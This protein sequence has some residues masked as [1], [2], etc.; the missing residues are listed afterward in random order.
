MSRLISKPK[1][2]PDKQ[3]KLDSLRK[4]D[5]TKLLWECPTCGITYTPS[6][7]KPLLSRCPYCFPEDA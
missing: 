5:Q 1:I 2:K 3:R 6:R 7:N 4:E